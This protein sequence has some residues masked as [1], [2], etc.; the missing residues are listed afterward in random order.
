MSY[1]LIAW[2]RHLIVCT[3]LLSTQILLHI[4]IVPIAYAATPDQPTITQSPT[5]RF[6]P[7][8]GPNGA[9]IDMPPEPVVR[10]STLRALSIAETSIPNSRAKP[11]T[12]APEPAYL[13]GDGPWIPGTR[14]A[15]TKRLDLYIGAHTFSEEEIVT[16]APLIE[17]A[18]RDA[19][20]AFG[21]TLRTRV[22]IG[23]YHPSVS[24]MENVR[25]LAYTEDRHAQVF[26]RA[27][28]DLNRAIVVA[29]HELG[30]QLEQ[31]RY[32]TEVQRRADTI[33]HEGVATW[34]VG[35]YWLEMQGSTDWKS[36][37]RNLNASGV[38][39]QLVTAEH[40]GANNAY[41]LWASFVDFLIE[42]Y[43][44][45]TIDAL[46]ISGRGRAHGSADYKGV[47]G[48]SLDELADEWRAWVHE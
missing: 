8:V 43:G 16:A 3:F 35:P 12:I 37:I 32:G 20:I 36:H 4:H 33:L 28:E 11:I 41:E 29:A 5:E 40:Y 1:R 30:H 31:E 19:E 10:R 17:Q 7:T 13:I 42:D 47:T 2:L 45:E 18:L 39:L 25:G 14:V 21:T 38:P 27:G 34:V 22:S 23:F 46:Y 9:P 6:T 48:K 44:T 24:P 15:Q 26:Y